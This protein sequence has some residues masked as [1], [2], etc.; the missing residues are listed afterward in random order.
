MNC[1]TFMPLNF[2][3]R[4][5]DGSTAY[6]ASDGTELNAHY[7][8]QSSFGSHMLA[9]E[10]SVVKVRDDAPVELLGPMGCSLQAG[11]G[12]VLNVLDPSPGSSIVVFGAGGVGRQASDWGP[13]GG[14]AIAGNCHGDAKGGYR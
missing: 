6:R 13:G 4:R 1:E 10:R 3:G 14:R 7:F 2:G 9:T 5:A 12:A 11:A 8:G